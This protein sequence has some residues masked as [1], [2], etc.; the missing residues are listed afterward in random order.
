MLLIINDLY[1]DMIHSIC[2][3]D[4]DYEAYVFL[5]LVVFVV[6]VVLPSP[7]SSHVPLCESRSPCRHDDRD[8]KRLGG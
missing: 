2:S 4:N 6:V 3:D 7:S 8:P 1:D 5:L